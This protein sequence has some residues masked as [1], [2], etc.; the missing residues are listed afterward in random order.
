MG[1]PQEPHLE[2]GRVLCVVNLERDLGPAWQQ[3]EEFG[4]NHGGE[5]HH[6]EQG[7]PR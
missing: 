3:V 6:L 7:N 2:Q 1:S 5:D 4:F